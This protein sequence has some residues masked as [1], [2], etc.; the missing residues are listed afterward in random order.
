MPKKEI[1][2]RRA[3]LL[4]LVTAG[5]MGLLFFLSSR[6]KFAFTL[7]ADSDKIIHA[8]AYMPLGLLF[9]LSLSVSGMRRRLLIAAA[10]FSLLYGVSDEIHQ[11]FVPGRYASVGDVIADAVG[12]F[13]GSLLG[14]YTR[15]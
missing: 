10:L 15:H 12:A 14:N 13:I 7:P 1:D 4:W 6:E 5:Y 3:V 9:Y 8:L 2:I 11:L